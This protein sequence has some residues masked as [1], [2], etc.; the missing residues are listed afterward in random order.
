MIKR[1]RP[2]TSHLCLCWFYLCFYVLYL[3]GL[4]IY[5]LCLLGLCFYLL[6]LSLFCVCTY[7]CSGY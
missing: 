2:A 7:E 6:Y 3:S 1:A 5:L 4:C